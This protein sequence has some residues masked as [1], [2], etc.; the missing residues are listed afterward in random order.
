MLA[1]PTVCGCAAAVRG[2]FG[3]AEQA[4]LPKSL[5]NVRFGSLS[6]LTYRPPDC[7]P[8]PVSFFLLKV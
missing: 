7:L 6:L 4:L 1:W 3:S 8:F 5:R 2:S